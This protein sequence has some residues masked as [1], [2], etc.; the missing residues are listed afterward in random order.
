MNYKLDKKDKYSLASLQIS[1]SKLTTA[2]I[3]ADLQLTNN[4]T[5]QATGIM[6][7]EAMLSGAGKF[8]R[9]ELIN[10]IRKI[11]ASLNISVGDNQITLKLQARTENFSK[12]VKIA[13]TLINEPDFESKE[14]NRIYLKTRNELVESKEDSRSFADDELRNCFYGKKDRKYSFSI[15]DL[16]EEIQLINSKHFK[17]WHNRF[18]SKTWTCSI[19]GPKD[20][21]ETFATL[22]DGIKKTTKLVDT[23]Y[24]HDPRPAKP[25]L[26]LKDIPSRQNI[27]FAIG[28]P[29]PITIHHPDYLPL[30]LGVAILGNWGGFA[31][32]LMSTVREKEGLTY[33]IYAR[34][35]GATDKEEGYLR[36]LTFF[37]PDKSTEAL[38]STYREISLLHKKGVEKDE[39]AH[40]KNILNTRNTLR[41]DST[42][43][44]LAE[45]H[46]YHK[47][48]FSIKEVLAHKAK[49]KTITLEA[50]NQAI[51]KY[52][53]PKNMS[54]TGAGPVK[55]V[56]KEIDK[57]FKSVQ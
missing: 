11:G 13:K 16:L 54:V 55:G 21:I 43:G 14:L 44:L 22:I 57:F 32:R 23:E 4:L 42:A 53:D 41:Q 29:L 46:T 7:A 50:V 27:D 19:A 31:G 17:I 39:L 51:T 10:Q 30:V 3:S 6:F 15:D 28:T 35:E 47:L 38:K 12:L 2:Y 37:A 18:L 25:K 24:L 48:G 8:D 45:L 56:K 26:F 36:I 20:S 34:I 9:E 1:G 52:L 49:L 40:F 33:T 5:E